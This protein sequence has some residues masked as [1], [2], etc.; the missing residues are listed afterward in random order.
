MHDTMRCSSPVAS[1]LYMVSLIILGQ[2]IVMNIFLA[3]LLRGFA[4]NEDEAKKHT[5]AQ[6]EQSEVARVKRLSAESLAALLQPR[7]KAPPAT[8]SFISGGGIP[9]PSKLAKP[10]A[11]RPSSS[12]GGPRGSRA[13]TPMVESDDDDAPSEST[14]IIVGGGGGG[15]GDSGPPPPPP[16]EPTTRI[17]MSSSSLWLFRKGDPLRQFL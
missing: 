5:A 11:S 17:V 14:D 16:T 7:P 15:G 1:A 6:G 4:G 8:S 9:S 2:F 13:V 10:A 12:H 3:I